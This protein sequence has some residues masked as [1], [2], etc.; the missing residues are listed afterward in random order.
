MHVN[1]AKERRSAAVWAADLGVCAPSGT[2]TPNPLKLAVRLLATLVIALKWPL[3]CTYAAVVAPRFTLSFRRFPADGGGVNRGRL[4]TFHLFNHGLT[5]FRFRAGSTRANGRGFRVIDP[6]TALMAANELV[7]LA[8]A[9]GL[10]KNQADR[11]AETLTEDVRSLVVADFHAGIDRIELASRVT[12]PRR[13]ED[14]LK[15]GRARL[16]DAATQPRMPS[17]LRAYAYAALAKLAAENGD[18][19][20][21]G[22]WADRG[23]ELYDGML[24]DVFSAAN[25]A[26]RGERTDFDKFLDWSLPLAAPSVWVARRTLSWLGPEVASE[27]ALAQLNGEARSLIQFGTENGCVVAGRACGVE[28]RREGRRIISVHLQTVPDVNK[29]F[30]TTAAPVPLITSRTWPAVGGSR[31][32]GANHV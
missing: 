25:K 28:I 13:A 31:V 1:H 26:T 18:K 30:S 12:D 16:H 32:S 5:R 24:R 19:G 21:A 22:V 14:L 7:Q 27:E 2:R 10:I 17:I 29:W 8:S 9:L 20:E 15:E 11:A 3:A 23:I 6:I 4:Q